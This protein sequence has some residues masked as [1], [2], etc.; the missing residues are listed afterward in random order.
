MRECGGRLVRGQ[1]P[2][3]PVHLIIVGALRKRDGS[4]G[5]KIADDIRSYRS[6]LL[7]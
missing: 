5:K 3:L 7:L 1:R 2:L 6:V 4:V